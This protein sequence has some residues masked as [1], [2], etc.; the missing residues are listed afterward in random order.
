MKGFAEARATDLSSGAGL[1]WRAMRLGTR[2]GPNSLASQ[3]IPSR[4]ARGISNRVCPLREE[5]TKMTNRFCYPGLLVERPDPQNEI[6]GRTALRPAFAW[7]EV[8]TA[9]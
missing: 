2:A 4:I 1:D 7:N 5:Y 3:T 6:K 8:A 9:L